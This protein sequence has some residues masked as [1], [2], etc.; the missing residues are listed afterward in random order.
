MF[1]VQI[2]VEANQ[3]LKDDES[4]VT[5]AQ[6]VDVLNSLHDVKLVISNMLFK[7]VP[8]NPC[9]DR[10]LRHQFLHVLLE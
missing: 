3:V 6:L 8:G 4:I 5:H 10:L 7:Q 2:A 9:F 1:R